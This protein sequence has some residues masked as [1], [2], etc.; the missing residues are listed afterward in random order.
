MESAEIFYLEAD[1]HDTLVRLRGKRLLRDVRGLGELED[2]LSDHDLIRVH[3]NF[4]V[5]LR[6]IREFPPRNDGNDWALRMEPPVHRIIPIGRT[7][8][9]RLWKAFEA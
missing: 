9:S 2:L 6:R 3:R 8:E 5:N 4:I 7:Y 1:G